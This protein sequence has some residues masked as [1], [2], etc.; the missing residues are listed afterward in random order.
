MS[1]LLGRLGLDEAVFAAELLA[2]T[3]VPFTYRIAEN[4]TPTDG[5]Y[6]NFD[7]ASKRVLGLARAEAMRDGYGWVSAQDLIW[8][9]VSRDSR[10]GAIPR[11][12]PPRSPSFISR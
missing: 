3:D 8:C 2:V 5:P 9:S 4:A 7:D 11:S 1:P 12:L 6:E 10:R